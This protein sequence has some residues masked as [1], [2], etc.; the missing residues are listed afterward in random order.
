MYKFLKDFLLISYLL[1]LYKGC[2]G[3]SKHTQS[4]ATRYK[5]PNINYKVR[6]T[7]NITLVVFPRHNSLQE[8]ILLIYCTDHTKFSE[9]NRLVI[10]R[11]MYFCHVVLKIGD[12]CS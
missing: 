2:K 8:S 12:I 1:F 10:A 4:R 5:T 3:V 6:V 11:N 7:L 9:L